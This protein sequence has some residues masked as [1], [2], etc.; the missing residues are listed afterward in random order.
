MEMRSSRSR[1]TGVEQLYTPQEVA[2]FCLDEVLKLVDID[3]KFLEPAGGTGVFIEALLSKN[4][5]SKNIISFDIQPKHHLVKLTENSLDE[6]VD[7]KDLIVVGN[8]PFGRNNSLSVPF[9]NHFAPSAKM[10]AYILPKSWRKWS[11]QDKLNQDFWLVKDLDLNTSFQNENKVPIDE[12]TKLRTVFQI[13][14]RRQ[15]KR[16]LVL[17]TIENR[18]YIEKVLCTEADVSLTVFGHGC[19]KVKTDFLDSQIQLKCF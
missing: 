9:F 13:W 17:P 18:G 8:P 12:R 3:N 2:N 11:I 7:E 6:I 10:I 5:E 15:I 14:E 16:P 1:K 4:V 19:G